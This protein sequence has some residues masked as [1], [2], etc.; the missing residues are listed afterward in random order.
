MGAAGTIEAV[1]AVLTLENQLVPATAG[2]QDCEFDGR[3]DCVKANARRIFANYGVSN[4]FGFGGN[5]AS[6]VFARGEVV[7]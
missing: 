1:A 3:V 7:S 4:S 5:D 2:L 6:L